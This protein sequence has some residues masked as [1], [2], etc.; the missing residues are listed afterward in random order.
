MEDVQIA[1]EGELRKCSIDELKAIGAGL[2]IAAEELADDRSKAQVMRALVAVLDA[3]ADDAAK[4]TMLMR[5]LP[6]APQNVANEI[7]ALLSGRP[8]AAAAPHPTLDAAKLLQ[9]LNLDMS[10]SNKFRRE[11]KITG[12]ICETSKDS[13]NYISLC[14]QINDGRFNKYKDE[15]IAIAVRKAVAPGSN[16]R[17]YLDAK[18]DLTLKGILS[19]I[20][21]TLQEKSSSELYQDLNNE[22]Q[23]DSEEPQKFVLRAM[24]LREKILQASSAEGSVRFDAQS[25]RDL[26]L[27]TVRTGLKDDAVKSQVEALVRRGATTPDEEL[28]R[29]LNLVASEEA[30][31]KLKRGDTKKKSVTI[32]ETNVNDDIISAVRGVCKDLKDDVKALREELKTLKE[33]SS[34]PRQRD[35]GCNYCKSQNRGNLCRHCFHCGAG[36]HKIQNCTRRNEPRQP[37][38][39]Q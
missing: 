3:L 12:T 13:L 25:V 17:T 4:R 16:L 22:F 24:E 29:E 28:I 5:M 14:S 31:R 26:F 11:F 6:Y 19:F 1:V 20:R 33:S 34:A 18:S 15:E 37:P 36:D 32:N 35:W 8:T 23:K 30:E 27:H 2:N 38:L 39:N 7:M 21:N 9:G 10:A